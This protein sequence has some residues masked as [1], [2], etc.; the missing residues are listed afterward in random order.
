MLY[1]FLAERLCGMWFDI[2]GKHRLVSVCH[3]LNIRSKHEPHREPY[4]DYDAEMLMYMFD[5]RF[6]QH[7]Y[8]WYEKDDIEEKDF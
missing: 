5:L 8:F 1:M 2:D 6:L 4:T 7:N 3:T